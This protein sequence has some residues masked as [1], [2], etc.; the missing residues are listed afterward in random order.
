MGKTF[1]ATV[2]L[3][4]PK[5]NGCA[6]LLS[7]SFLRCES[8]SYHLSFV[9]GVDCSSFGES[10]P[11]FQHYPQLTFG[12]FIDSLNRTNNIAGWVTADTGRKYSSEI[13]CWSTWHT[14]IRI[15]QH[16]PRYLSSLLRDDVMENYRSSSCFEIASSKPPF[17]GHEEVLCCWKSTNLTRVKTEQCCAE[18]LVSLARKGG[19]LLV[20]KNPVRSRADAR[21]APRYQP[22]GTMNN[23]CLKLPENLIIPFPALLADNLFWRD[24]LFE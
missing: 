3:P 20:I 22:P 12:N 23:K 24:E 14:T 6:E 10:C 13:L 15:S 19:G 17:I 5:L 4:I 2:L 11:I 7:P 1:N 18:R 16:F 8:C 21:G 9:L